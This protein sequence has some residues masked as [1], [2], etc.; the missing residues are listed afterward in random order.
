MAP[1]PAGTASCMYL[2]RLWTRRTASA[3][4]SEPAATSAEYS[5]RLWPATKS[6]PMRF[7]ESAQSAATETVKIAGWV[8]AVSFNSSSVPSKQTFEIEKPSALSASSKIARDAGYFSASS[9]PMPEYCEACPGNM[10]ATLPIKCSSLRTSH[11]HVGQGELLFDFLVHPR[12]R[13]TGG[14]ADGVLDG[15]GV[16][17]AVADNANAADSQKRRAAILRV[18]HGPL[19]AFQS[20]FRKQIAQLRSDRAFVTLAQKLDD[21]HGQCFANFQR[22]VANEAVAD[23]H[24]HLAREEIIPFHVAHEVHRQPLETVVDGARQL[25][26]LDLLLAD[27]EQANAWLA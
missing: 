3:K 2:P 24:V 23:N 19:D 14:D 6:A 9:L 18:V 21:L 1:C 26:A 10:N 20:P 27:R 16:R 25:V 22:D 7:S 17:A 12:A 11:L 13:Q 8:L 5:P 15:V 4:F